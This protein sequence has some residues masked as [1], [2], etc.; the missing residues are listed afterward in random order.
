MSTSAYCKNPRMLQ[1]LHEG[2]LG[3][4]IDL[5]A[6]RLLKE[7]HCTQSAYRNLRIVSD[8]SHWLAKKGLGLRELNEQTVERYLEFRCR[9]RYPYLVPRLRSS[10]RNFGNSSLCCHADWAPATYSSTIS[11]SRSDMV[12]SAFSAFS[13]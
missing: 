1:R 8:F 6:T 9:N 13:L 12:Y 4:H 5:F 7:G 2:P 11:R 10:V 3:T